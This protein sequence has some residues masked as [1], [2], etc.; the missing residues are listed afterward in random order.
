M[1]LCRNIQ[2]AQGILWGYS[3]PPIGQLWSILHSLFY[4]CIYPSMSIVSGAL[5]VCHKNFP[6]GGDITHTTPTQP[7]KTEAYLCLNTKANESLSGLPT[8]VWVTSYRSKEDSKAS[9]SP[10]SPPQYQWWKLAPRGS[11][12]YFQAAQQAE[13]DLLSVLGWTQVSAASSYLLPL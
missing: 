10:K 2:N 12:Y 1:L 9:T 4:L 6:L 11:L 3:F 13:R 8:G 5:G 7:R